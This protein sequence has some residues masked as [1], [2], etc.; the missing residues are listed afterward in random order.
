MESLKVSTQP[1]S[2]L[3]PLTSPGEGGRWDG[4]KKGILEV[5]G[6][7]DLKK[8]NCCSTFVFQ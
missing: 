7:M 6:Q 2:A 8:R 5:T 3:P 1:E 4:K